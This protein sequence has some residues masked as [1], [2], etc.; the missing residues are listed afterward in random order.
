MSVLKDLKDFF[1]YLAQGDAMEKVLAA[2]MTLLVGF[3]AFLLCFG[4]YVACDS[5]FLDDT[6]GTAEVQGRAYSPDH[7]QTMWYSTMTYPSGSWTLFLQ[8][9]GQADGV[10]VNEAAYRT[11]ADG[12][13]L[14]VLYRKGR[15]S[16]WLYITEVRFP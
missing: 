16:D 4:A 14:G 2:I 13:R 7:Y 3:V 11:V 12:T 1:V 6:E 15:F 9:R 8:M 10:S 5:W